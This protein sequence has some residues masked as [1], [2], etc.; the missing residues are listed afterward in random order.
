LDLLIDESLKADGYTLK[1]FFL[2]AMG[3]AIHLHVSEPRG[4]MKGRGVWVPPNRD[5]VHEFQREKAA[6]LKG[7]YREGS[8]D[9]I[10]PRAYLLRILIVRF[11]SLARR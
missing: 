8:V 4:Y 10:I 9:E 3:E 11:K 1:L 6:W 5:A 7:L 2:G